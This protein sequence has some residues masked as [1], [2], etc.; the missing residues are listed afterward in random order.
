M[1][2]RRLTIVP[3]LAACVAAAGLAIPPDALSSA[4][5]KSV[6]ITACKSVVRKSVYKCLGPYTLGIP[7]SAPKV[8]FHVVTMGSWGPA[9]VTFNILDVASRQP[10]VNPVSVNPGRAYKTGFL[11]WFG[12]NG[13]FPK[14]TIVITT[15][16]GGK[17]VG[18]G[19]IFRFV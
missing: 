18:A 8:A 12:L 13:P 9:T 6:A 19:Q 10:L 1:R 15:T 2:L 11:W 3:G 7:A 16:V 14:T 4:S 5:A 17:M